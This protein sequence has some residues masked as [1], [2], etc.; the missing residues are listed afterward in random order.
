MT[1]R[2]RL[3]ALERERGDLHEARV[4]LD[5]RIGDALL[6]VRRRRESTGLGRGARGSD[7]APTL[8]E[9]ADLLGMSR[10]NAYLLIGQAERSKSP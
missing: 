10:Q 7:W 6:E 1:L 4:E 9:A 2:E 3:Q 5:R 8:A